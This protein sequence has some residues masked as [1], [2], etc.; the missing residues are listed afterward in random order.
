[1]RVQRIASPQKDTAL[2]SHGHSA[3]GAKRRKVKKSTENPDHD[4]WMDAGVYYVVD[5]ATP[6]RNCILGSEISPQSEKV[7]DLA[8][9]A[10]TIWIQPYDPT[11]HRALSSSHR[12]ETIL[13]QQ[14]AMGPYLEQQPGPSRYFTKKGPK[15]CFGAEAAAK[16]KD[17][18]SSGF[19]TVAQKLSRLWRPV[20][21]LHDN[22]SKWR[23]SNGKK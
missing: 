5:I 19:G 4:V 1:M 23:K 16:E 21:W 6:C 10:L 13:S 12:N 7:F 20:G 15:Y 11:R 8:P 22:K 3:E 14:S 2:I 18:I 17:R 9:N